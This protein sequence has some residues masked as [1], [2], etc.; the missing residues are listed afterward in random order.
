MNVITI[1]VGNKSD[2]HD[3]REVGIDEGRSLAEAE[4]MF[5]METSALDSSNV[6]AAFETI[7]KEIY[8]ILAKRVRLSQESKPDTVFICNGKPVATK[9]D[10]SDGGKKSRSSK[11]C[12]S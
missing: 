1:L 3:V 10:T 2:L 8:N 7:V 5:F 6:S 4:G 9:G 12:S 11:C